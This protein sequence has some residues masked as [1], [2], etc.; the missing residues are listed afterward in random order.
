MGISLGR[1]LGRRPRD[2]ATEA[3]YRQIVEQA[4]EPGFYR[5][6]GVPDTLDGRFE[7]LALHLF[8]VL[9]RLRR[10]GSDAASR[11]LTQSLIDR[12][13]ADMDGNLRE[14]GAGDLGVGRRVRRMAEGF[15]GRLAA[16][17][18]GLAQGPALLATAIRR[19][20]YGTVDP[21]L[22]QVAALAAYVR[23]CRQLLGGVST[24]DLARGVVR[25]AAVPTVGFAD[26]GSR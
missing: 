19:N 10:D 5:E 1:I 4:R 16:Y 12:L 24:A 17:D 3:L 22:H 14:M 9:N 7:M 2:G 23:G 21:T 18:A 25:F 11:A 8:L 13:I 20:V 15:N 26:L 6:L